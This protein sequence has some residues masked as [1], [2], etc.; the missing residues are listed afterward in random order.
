MMQCFPLK[1]VHCLKHAIQT[2]AVKSMVCS[3]DF[4]I[5][6]TESITLQCSLSVY[7][8]KCASF[9]HNRVVYMLPIGFGSI[10]V[11]NRILW[12]HEQCL[13]FVCSDFSGACE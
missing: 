11:T 1:Y 7:K 10:H 4:R 5:C 2:T 9:W 6:F 8:L 13:P 12:M 3:S